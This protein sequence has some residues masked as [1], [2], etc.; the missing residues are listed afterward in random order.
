[1]SNLL[2]RGLGAVTGLFEQQ[3]KEKSLQETRFQLATD[4]DTA[5]R[6]L[7]SGDPRINQRQH[8]RILEFIRRNDA[9]QQA[10]M[11]LTKKS[12]AQRIYLLNQIILMLTEL[13]RDIEYFKK[14][15]NL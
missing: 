1:M 9:T 3:A 15:E 14:K 7:I 8:D 6:E 12:K 2:E 5:I 11:D 13:L 10:W 4:A